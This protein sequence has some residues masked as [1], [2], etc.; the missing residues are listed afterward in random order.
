MENPEE[1]YASQLHVNQL[2]PYSQHIW[3]ENE[4]IIWQINT[5]NQEAYENIVLPLM[6]PEFSSF[7]IE[8]DDVECKILDKTVVANSRQNLIEEYYF[9]ESDRYINIRFAT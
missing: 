3:R 5:L 2:H 4:K 8:R 1:S 6:K 7:Y 9:G